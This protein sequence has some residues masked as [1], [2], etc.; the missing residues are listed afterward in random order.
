M[1]HHH[2]KRKKDLLRLLCRHPMV[3]VFLVVLLFGFI[4]TV[5]D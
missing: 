5:D 1:G 2:K 3:M 4:G